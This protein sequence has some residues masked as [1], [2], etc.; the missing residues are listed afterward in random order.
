MHPVE[1]FALAV[2]HSRLLKNSFRLWDLV[3]P[4]YRRFLEMLE[5]PGLR[6]MINGTDLVLLSHDLH[7]IP[8][9]Y[10]PEMWSALMGKVRPGDVVADVGAF[11]GLYTVALAN[12]VGVEGRVYAFE[13]DPVSFGR[14]CRHM[15]L[16]GLD[17]RVRT[18]PWAV[19]AESTLLGFASGRGLE[20]TVIPDALPAVDRVKSVH[21]DSIFAGKQLDILKVDVEGYEQHVLRGACELMRDEERAPR[22]I[23]VEVHPF[24]WE[25]FGVTDRCLLENLWQAGYR[26]TDLAGNDVSEIDQYGV[27][28]A[29]KDAALRD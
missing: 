3:R 5:R 19:G 8:E 18:F 27:I 22:A 14:L 1:K 24:A 28:L 26:V 7:G 20:S 10:E 12:R 29:Q 15:T 25:S 16:N 6:R 13:P 23:F 9:V 21:L 4:R 11:I 2:R 17:D